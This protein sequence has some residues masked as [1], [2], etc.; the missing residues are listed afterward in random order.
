MPIYEASQILPR[1]ETTTEIIETT[2]EELVNSLPLLGSALVS[3]EREVI[4]GYA[5]VSVVVRAHWIPT[6]NRRAIRNSVA[7]LN[8]RLMV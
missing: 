7:R 3:L 6:L 2:M 4:Y 8:K 1:H 5:I